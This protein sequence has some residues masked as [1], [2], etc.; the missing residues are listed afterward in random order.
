M[1]LG[2]ILYILTRV[3]PFLDMPISLS[4][5]FIFNPSARTCFWLYRV[6]ASSFLVGVAIADVVLIIRTCALWGDNRR[7]KY[8]LYGLF[9][10][11]FAPMAVSVNLALNAFDYT[12]FPDPNIL[13]GCFV[14]SNRPTAVDWYGV[15]FGILPIFETAVFILTIVQFK[16]LKAY[17]KQPS[18]FV[19]TL[20]RDGVLFYFYLN[21]ISIT[22][23]IVL[24]RAPKEMANLLFSTH[25]VIHSLLSSR[26]LLNLR[27]AT[28]RTVEGTGIMTN[29]FSSRYID[30]LETIRFNGNIH[31]PDDTELIDLTSSDDREDVPF[32]G[33]TSIFTSH[34]YSHRFG[35]RSN[36]V[37]SSDFGS[38]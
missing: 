25:R 30:R 11:V 13:P 18:V 2:K 12:P 28:L 29:M 21:V 26:L 34:D 3:L 27:E 7:V 1:N 15:Y 16:A 31:N 6:T 8:F 23:L 36:D 9:A 37:I 33:S 4:H 24:L 19:R 10:A 22:Y 20:Y 35:E 14:V 17:K 32:K 38:R 5:E